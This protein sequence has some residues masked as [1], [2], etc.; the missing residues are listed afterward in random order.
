METQI[1]DDSGRRFDFD[2][3]G[4]NATI[5]YDAHVGAFVDTVMRNRSD[6]MR[7]FGAGRSDAQLATAAKCALEAFQTGFYKKRKRSAN[8]A[9][10]R[11]ITITDR[12]VH[13]GDRTILTET[14]GARYS[15]KNN[16]LTT[17]DALP[18]RAVGM[19]ED[20]RRQTFKPV[21]DMAM[22]TAQEIAEGDK[23]GWSAMQR[24]GELLREQHEQNLNKL[25]LVGNSD[26]NLMGITNHVD[27]RRR[28]AAF[29]WGSASS[30]DIY[31]DYNAVL[32]DMFTS[33]D[34]DGMPPLSILPRI[35]WHYMNTIQFSPGGT[36]TTLN[37]YIMRNNTGHAIEFD[38]N[39]REVDSL[40]GPGGLFLHNEDD[41]LRVT[42]PF[43][44]MP[45]SPFQVNEI[46]TRI[47]IE[48]RFAGVQISDTDKVELVEGSAAGWVQFQ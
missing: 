3:N 27:I 16:G 4:I 31:D 28:V 33:L 9:E 7:E 15:P 17:P 20:S 36:D 47:L 24:K 45:H 48:S 10:G 12:G 42:M 32:R 1:N 2:P 21:R 14:Y 44:M 13:P 11:W 18:E 19:A 34:E 40:G 37:Q 23:Q 26:F 29:N 6:Y 30:T 39:M 8:W 25:I 38:S 22:I 46:T 5:D 43:W 41:V 35:Q